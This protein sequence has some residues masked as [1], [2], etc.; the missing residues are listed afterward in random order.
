MRGFD[1]EVRAMRRGK[2]GGLGWGVMGWAIGALAVAAG[3]WTVVPQSSTAQGVTAGVGNAALPANPA[4][5]EAANEIGRAH[6]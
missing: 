5:A 2:S 3:A 1:R 6:V 4:P